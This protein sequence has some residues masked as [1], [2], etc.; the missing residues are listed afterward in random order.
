MSADSVSSCIMLSVISYHLIFAQF[1]RVLSWCII[2]SICWRMIT[3]R[4]RSALHFSKNLR[5]KSRT[6]RPWALT[7]LKLPS[8]PQP[9]GNWF[10]WPC[11]SVTSSPFALEKSA[12]TPS[13]PPLLLP[14][15]AKK[16]QILLPRVRLCIGKLKK[17][18]SLPRWIFSP[19]K[20]WAPFSTH[21]RQHPAFS[22]GEAGKSLEL[23]TISVEFPVQ[24]IDFSLWPKLIEVT[25]PKRSC[26]KWRLQDSASRALSKLRRS[27][28]SAKSNLGKLNVAYF[29]GRTLTITPK[30]LPVHQMSMK[31][32]EILFCVTKLIHPSRQIN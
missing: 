4:T 30:N 28:G 10:K 21:L 1:S 12:Q 31:Y 29:E 7:R 22:F 15:P 9:K 8:S 24:V 6:F 27:F 2:Y 13:L 18:T 20:M 17:F 16:G 14:L 5:T 32:H 25:R 3:R 26:L 11:N 19:A 23:T